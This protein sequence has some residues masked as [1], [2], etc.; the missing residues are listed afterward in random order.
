MKQGFDFSC[1]ILHPFKTS[2]SGNFREIMNYE[3]CNM[4][5]E[6]N[7]SSLIL[8]PSSFQKGAYVCRIRYRKL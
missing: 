4:K 1:L 7:I 3:E 2:L 5:E 8:H 6:F